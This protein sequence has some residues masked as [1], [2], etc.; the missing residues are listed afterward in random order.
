[1]DREPE[2]D[3]IIG[4]IRNSFQDAA[5]VYTN[6]SCFELYKILKAIFPHAKAWTNHDHVWTQIGSV[7]YDI[8]GKREAGSEGLLLMEDEPKM[9]ER[10]HH[11]TH[12]S[13]WRIKE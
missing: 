10:A 6:G 7:W 12:R 13:S 8:N 11:W 1:M 4:L 5:F 3:V 9:F 2:P